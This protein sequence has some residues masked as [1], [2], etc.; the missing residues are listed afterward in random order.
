MD[1][2]KNA[3]TPQIIHFIEG[4]HEKKNHPFWGITILGNP[5]DGSS[6]IFKILQLLAFSPRHGGYSHLELLSA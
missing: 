5:L 2:S 3:G 6:D 4:F 1:V